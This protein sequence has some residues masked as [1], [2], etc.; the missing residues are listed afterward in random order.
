MALTKMTDDLNIIKKL[1]NEPNDVGGL[2]PEVLKS[3]FDKGPNKI[4]NYINDTLIPETEDKFEELEG[5]GRTTET[6]KKNADNIDKNKKDINDLQ[7]NKADKKTTYTKLEINDIDSDIKLSIKNN[8]K[9][10]SKL[11]NDK[12]DKSN[13]Y[14]KKEIDDKDTT[15]Q[16]KIKSN[17]DNISSLNNDKADKSNTYTKGE[18]DSKNQDLQ[19]K[20]GKNITD[21][22]SLKN[23]KADKSKVN[24]NSTNI[25]N[26]I[27]SSNAH[28]ANKISY[29]GKVPNTNNVSGALDTLQ[30]DVN[31]FASGGTIEE[32]IHS[33]KDVD[34]H[35]HKNLKTHLDTWE[36]KI[37]D[38]EKNLNESKEFRLNPTNSNATVISYPDNTKGLF[39]PEVKG[40]KP[41]Y[42]SVKNGDFHDDTDKWVAKAG[43]SAFVVNN[44]I[45]EFLPNQRYGR[46]EQNMPLTTGNKYF[47]YAQIKTG[48]GQSVRLA[49]A[50]TLQGTGNFQENYKISTLSSSVDYFVFQIYKDDET[51]SQKIYV[52]EALAINMTAN[53]IENYTEEQM[54]EIVRNGYWEGLKT[55]ALSYDLVSRGKNLFN[56]N[57][58]IYNRSDVNKHTADIIDNKL[59]S[60]GLTLTNVPSVLVEVQPNTKYTLKFN[61]YTVPTKTLRCYGYSQKPTNNV[62]NVQSTVSDRRGQNNVSFTTH[63]NENFLFIGFYEDS[64]VTKGMYISEV[65]L[66]RNNTA[67]PYEPY[68]ETKTGFGSPRPLLCIGDIKDEIND[69]KKLIYRNSGAIVLDGTQHTSFSSKA[70]DGDSVRVYV[71]NAKSATGYETQSAILNDPRYSWSEI[72]THAGYNFN[73]YGGLLYL[74]LRFD[75]T[76]WDNSHIPTTSEIQSYFKSLHDNGNPLIVRYQLENPEVIND[77]EQGFKFPSPLPAYQNGDLVQIPTTI[78]EIHLN[79]EN[80]IVMDFK[81]IEI[82]ELID[83]DGNTLNGV[84]GDDKVTITLDNK[85][86]GVVHSKCR[87]DPS[88]CLNI[89]PN[90]LIPGNVNKRVEQNTLGITDLNKDFDKEEKIND[91]VLLEHELAIGEQGTRL[92]NAENKVN[93]HDTQ[94]TNMNNTI[95][96]QINNAI[97]GIRTQNAAIRIET[98]TSDPSNPEIGRIWLRT[99]L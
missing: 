62:F 21:I 83:S 24:Q 25:S 49:G 18:V 4:K 70:P 68:V 80:T 37:K 7:V 55:S 15:L 67:T 89:I 61:D 45:A 43:A 33:R 42:Q 47:V 81:C 1:D 84:I 28:T 64:T 16:G 10:I 59:V 20:I 78:K 5:E 93:K 11:N 79:N 57:T 27:K 50:N 98:R 92:D 66:E 82:L 72:S 23:N 60:Q 9:N 99:D 51:A 32:V 58:T 77:G 56:V 3:T 44:T 52:K 91:M 17:E 86:T 94:L 87:R 12:A 95:E 71:D 73:M 35:T 85:Y 30:E 46:I 69:N 38:N 26:H 14:T 63:E 6:I 8:E 65:Q 19:N 97:P 53:G 13:T 31:N 40:V 41:I 48:T 76:P 96:N 74:S 54:L 29:S 88:T 90:G 36:S 75:D 2:T 39:Y 22:T 34:G